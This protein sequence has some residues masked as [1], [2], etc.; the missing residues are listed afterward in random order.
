MNVARSSL[1]AQNIGLQTAGLAVGGYG[2]PP[3]NNSYAGVESYNGSSWTEGADLNNGRNSSAGCGTQTAAITAGGDPFPGVG[4]K[5]ETW[6]GS[7]WTEVNALNT[8]NK[9]KVW[10]GE[11]QQQH[12]VVVD[13]L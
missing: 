1:S 7:S 6:N 8:S 3:P 10:L 9:I 4:T 12:N 13:H 5:T 2:E 11:H